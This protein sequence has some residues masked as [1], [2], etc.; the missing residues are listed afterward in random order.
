M[1]IV[2][3]NAGVKGFLFAPQQLRKSHDNRFLFIFPAGIHR[4][5]AEKTL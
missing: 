4:Q 3:L 1:I 5:K 2:F